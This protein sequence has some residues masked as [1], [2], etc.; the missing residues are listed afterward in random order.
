MQKYNSLVAMQQ[1]SCK[2]FA[3]RPMYGTKFKGQ[4]RWI[5]FKE[6]GDYVEHVR[7]GLRHYGLEEG[8]TVAIIS[9]NC[10]EWAVAAYAAMGL[11][12]RVVGMYE[13]QTSTEWEY[14]LSDCKASIVF[15]HNSVIQDVIERI[16]LKLPHIKH[17][18][19]IHEDETEH[20][21]FNKLIKIG[22]QHPTPVIPAQPDDIMSIIYTSGTTDKPKG[23]LLS[24]GNLLGQIDAVKSR[25]DFTPDDRTLSFLPWAHIFG[26]SGEV[27]LLIAL[28]FSAGLSESVSKILENLGEIKPTMLMSVPRIFNRIY[29]NVMNK[30]HRGPAITRW[31]FKHGMAGAQN[32][33]EGRPSTFLQNF[34][35]GIADKLIFK[36]IR[37]AFGGRLK[38]AI[39]GGAALQIE[40]ASFIA[41]LGITVYEG[42][43]LSETS[44]MVSANYPGNIKI[45][46]VGKT[47]TGVTVK[48][49]TSVGESDIAGAGEIIVYGP[50]V[51]KGYHNLPQET[52]AVMTSDGGFRTGDVGYFDAEGYLNICGRVKEQFKLQNGKYVVPS[53]IEDLINLSTYVS[54]SLI[55]GDNREY[56][57]AVVNVNL[58]EVVHF[59]KSRGLYHQVHDVIPKE[60]VD[61]LL[62]HVEIQALFEKIIRDQCASVRGYEVPRKF[63]LTAEEWSANTGFLTQTFKLRRMPIISHYADHIDLLYHESRSF[64]EVANA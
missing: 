24:H 51:M 15:A 46:S 2:T 44:P 40:V 57:V 10:V 13:N 42:Y 56:T 64:L 29:E 37:A 39:S 1:E 59:A 54:Y 16:S 18:I 23:V 63:M 26:H 50:N 45:G 41:N 6:F 58:D 17:V 28:G 27:H 4:W 19:N 14:I 5:T 34:C 53:V 8:D 3:D 55:Y 35:F 30:I 20:L 36:K 60:D 62:N 49:D 9:R 7:G 52:A 25:Y 61:N 31:L 32:R 11:R 12:G 33:R 22:K 48:I 47:L 21:C 38:Y 43:G